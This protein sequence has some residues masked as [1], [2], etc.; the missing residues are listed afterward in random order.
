MVNDFD[1]NSYCYYYYHDYQLRPS[2]WPGAAPSWQASSA[3][4]R[5]RACWPP[6]AATSPVRNITTIMN[7]SDNTYDDNNNTL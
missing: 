2:A 3:R 1:I 5:W 4:P 6:P 7:H